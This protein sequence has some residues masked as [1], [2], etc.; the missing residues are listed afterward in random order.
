VGP[1]TVGAAT[2]GAAAVEAFSTVEATA[3]GVA[4]TEAAEVTSVR[5]A[6]AAEA[7]SCVTSTCIVAAEV[8]SSTVAMSAVIEV[9]P[10]ARTPIKAEAS[11]RAAEPRAGPDKE[12]V[13]E[14]TG[15]VVAVR[16]A[17]VRVISIVAVSALWSWANVGRADSKPNH[18]SLCVCVRC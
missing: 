5:T 9:W 14:P 2:V 17:C 12:T 6:F 1:T 16:G 13:G 10:E 18:N 4:A 15:T 3:V 8:T 11:I 7:T